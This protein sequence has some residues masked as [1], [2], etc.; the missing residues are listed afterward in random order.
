MKYFVIFPIKLVKILD[1][2][3]AQALG[4][5][6]VLHVP[7]VGTWMEKP[8]LAGGVDLDNSVHITQ[9]HLL[10]VDVNITSQNLLLSF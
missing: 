4:R 2:Q 8:K 1:V 3:S 6:F 10:N 5:A 7:R 9:L